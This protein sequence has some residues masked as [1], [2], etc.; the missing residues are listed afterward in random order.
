MAIVIDGPFPRSV[1]KGFTRMYGRRLRGFGDWFDVTQAAYNPMATSSGSASSSPSYVTTRTWFDTVPDPTKTYN[2]GVDVYGNKVTVAQWD[3][4]VKLVMPQPAPPAGKVSIVAQS[5]GFRSSPYLANGQKFPMQPYVNTSPTTGQKFPDLS[6]FPGPPA[7]YPYPGDPTIPL[8][9]IMPAVTPQAR[10]GGL[11]PNTWWEFIS[12][13]KMIVWDV[14]FN[15]PVHNGDPG[16]APEA[17]K[18]MAPKEQAA[19]GADVDHT[20]RAQQATNRI[21]VAAGVAAVGAIAA[22]GV[23]ASVAGA[24]AGAGAAGGGA[25]AAGIETAPSAGLATGAAAP[26]MTDIGLGATEAVPVSSA[27]GGV[28]TAAVPAGIETGAGAAGAGGLGIGATAG[29]GGLLTT[30]AGLGVSLLKPKP[31]TPA[32]TT[33]ANVTPDTGQNPLLASLGLGN[34]DPKILVGGAVLAALVYLL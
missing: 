34:V 24:A 10:Y 26:S 8:D 18:L 25:P 12:W 32:A 5:P 29:G 1:Q 17:I 28:A 15:D 30:A 4:N 31:T 33:P 20:N 3:F 14:G 13:R 21:V 27:A 7:G 16:N 2:Y 22:A 9:S 19:L 23:I 6:K 11:D